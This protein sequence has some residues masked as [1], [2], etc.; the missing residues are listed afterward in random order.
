MRRNCARG[1]LAYY[2]DAGRIP[3]SM[4]SARLDAA[5]QY[6]RRIAFMPHYGALNGTIIPVSISI[7][8]ANR[9]SS[10]SAISLIFTAKYKIYTQSHSDQSALAG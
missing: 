10:D 1:V 7:A 2:R 6:A 3:G 8:V 5:H 4:R 9:E